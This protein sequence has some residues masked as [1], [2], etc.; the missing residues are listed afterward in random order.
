MFISKI[1]KTGSTAYSKKYTS[2]E[3]VK[4]VNGVLNNIRYNS[5]MREQY[6]IGNHLEPDFQDYN[7]KIINDL[8][9]K[10]NVNLI[11]EYTTY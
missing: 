4:L 11:N 5:I 3:V 7:K 9:I 10:L 6:G 8:E 2:I 1:C